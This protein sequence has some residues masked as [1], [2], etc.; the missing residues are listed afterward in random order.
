MWH[1]NEHERVDPSDS[2][3]NGRVYRCAWCHHSVPVCGGL[4]YYTYVYLA[5]AGCWLAVPASP[6]PTGTDGIC[7]AHLARVRAGTDRLVS[8]A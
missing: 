5:D 2:W 8:A 3:L 4:P 1:G 7:P 6:V